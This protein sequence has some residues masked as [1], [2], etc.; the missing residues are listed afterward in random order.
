MTPTIP[1]KRDTQAACAEASQDG[2]SLHREDRQAGT[3]VATI[4]ITIF[5]FAVVGYTIIAL[6]AA[7]KPS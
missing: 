7:S 5:M 6:L 2:E 1:A 4:M 3:A